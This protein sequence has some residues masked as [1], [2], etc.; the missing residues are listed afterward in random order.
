LSHGPKKVARDAKSGKRLFAHGHTM[1]MEVENSNENKIFFNFYFIPRGL[2][3]EDSITCS[4]Y[5]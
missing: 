2:E 4:C 3:F 5:G 1:Y